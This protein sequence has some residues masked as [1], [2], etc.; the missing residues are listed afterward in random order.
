MKKCPLY[1]LEV[2]MGQKYCNVS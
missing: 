1:Q 2:E